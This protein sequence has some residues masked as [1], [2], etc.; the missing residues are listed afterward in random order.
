MQSRPTSVINTWANVVTKPGEQVFATERHRTTATLSTALWW[1]LLASTVAILLRLLNVELLDAWM[2]DRNAQDWE[3]LPSFIS[4]LLH[5]FQNVSIANT[6][7]FLATVSLFGKFWIYS[8]LFDL[9]GNS[10]YIASFYYFAEFPEWSKVVVKITF[11]PALFLLK[12][13]VYHYLAILLGGRGQFG[14]YAYLLA[15]ISVPITVIHLIND[16][17]PLVGGK[18]GAILTP[19]PDLYWY[20]WMLA[21]TRIISACTIVYWLVLFYFATK[22]EHEMRWK[23]AIVATLGSYLMNFMISSLPEYLLLGLAEA[24]RLLLN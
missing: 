10:A 9:I 24:R 18:L 5:V 1:I 16:F 14:R 13:G 23:Q 6:H 19:M 12:A 17:L 11:S 2:N 7:L 3:L 22:V 21:P 20:S 4:E 15:S 8:G